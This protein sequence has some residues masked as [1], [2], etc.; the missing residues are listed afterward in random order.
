[1]YGPAWGDQWVVDPPSACP[2]GLAFEGCYV[3]D[4]YNGWFSKY[5]AGSLCPE[6]GDGKCYRIDDKDPAGTLRQ[7]CCSLDHV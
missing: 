1:M 6:D 3:W 7:V 4:P 5:D 2:D